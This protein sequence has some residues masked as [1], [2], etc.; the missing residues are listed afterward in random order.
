MFAA[1]HTHTA[2]HTDDTRRF[3]PSAPQALPLEP[4]DRGPGDVAGRYG[5]GL[6]EPDYRRVSEAGGLPVDTGF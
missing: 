3:Y 4:R 2:Y 1:V 6:E 5:V